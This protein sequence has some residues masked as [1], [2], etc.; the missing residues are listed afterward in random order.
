MTY[1]PFRGYDAW[2]TA[3]PDDEYIG[4]DEHLPDGLDAYGHLT[5]TLANQAPAVQTSAKEIL[6][7]LKSIEQ[8]LYWALDPEE[9]DA[10]RDQWALS[11]IEHA[12]A[13]LDLGHEYRFTLLA[14]PP[15]PNA[16][17]E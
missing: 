13:L 16:A 15:P 12:H 11:L 8:C 2:K 1:D 14:N 5:W 6:K 7:Q 17:Q 9:K 10:K 4:E 3:S